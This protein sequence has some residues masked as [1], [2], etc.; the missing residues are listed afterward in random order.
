MAAEVRGKPR[1][2]GVADERRHPLDRLAGGRQQTDG[3]VQPQLL[4]VAGETHP[5][6]LAKQPGQVAGARSGHVI[7]QKTKRHRLGQMQFQIGARPL[8]G[9]VRQ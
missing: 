6:P 1:R 9:I 2:V 3:P 8:E 4:H 7:G 5:P